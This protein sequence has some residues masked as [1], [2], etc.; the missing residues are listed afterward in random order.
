[1]IHTS[2]P[3]GYEHQAS[4][5]INDKKIILILEGIENKNN[6]KD[7]GM[8]ERGKWASFRRITQDLAEEMARSN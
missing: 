6:N 5:L 4:R 3:L 2:R 7:Q 8:S 1:M